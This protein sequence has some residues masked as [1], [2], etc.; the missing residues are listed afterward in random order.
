MASV[1]FEAAEISPLS[2]LILAVLWHHVLLRLLLLLS[3]KTRVEGNAQ[4][5]PACLPP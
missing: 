5:R 2:Y 4:H 3:E 1:L